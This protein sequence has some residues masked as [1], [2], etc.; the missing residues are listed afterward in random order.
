MPAEHTPPSFDSL[1][2]S[3]P[4]LQAVQ[5]VGYETPSPI[6][7]QC[8]PLLLAGDDLLGQAQTGTGKTAA[9]ALPLLSRIDTR[10]N[11]PQ[12][13][14]LA[15]TRELAIQVAEAFQTYAHHLKNFHVLP[16]Y[17][18][19]PYVQQLRALKRGAQV[20]VGTPGR[21]MDHIRRGTLVLDELSALVLDEADEMLRMGFIE[22][23]EWIL[24]QTPEN[25]QT[26][27]FSATM[28]PVI[29]KVANRHLRNAKEIHIKSSTSTAKTIHQRF[30]QVSAGRK[31]DALTRILEAE[32]IEAMLVFVRTKLLTVELADKLSARGFACQALNGDIAQNQREKTVNRLKKGEL[33]ILIA[34][35]VAARGLDVE[36]ISH[37]LN[38]DIPSDT[39][40]YVHRI[41]RTGRAGRKGE[42]ILFVTPKERRLLHSIEKATR[43]VIEPFRMPSTSDIN[44]QRIARFKQNITD[45]LEEQDLTLF[46][47]LMEEYQQ[48]Y[49]IE[50]IQVAAALAHLAQGS[51]PLLLTEEKSKPGKKDA[52]E[53][54][55]PGKR[56]AWEK[57]KPR[58]KSPANL[59]YTPIPLKDFPEIEMVRYRVDVGYAH[60]V[61][62]GNIVGAIANEAD[63]DSCYIGHIE[64]FDDFTTVDLPEG[65]P[66][67]TLHTLRKARVCGRKLEL[68][69]LRREPRANKFGRCQ[70]Q[71]KTSQENLA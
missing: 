16:V 13:L 49:E 60:D 25:R 33:D 61:K 37:V 50:P 26:A 69:E 32:D 1:G 17:G 45:T 38:Y 5:D 48:E 66:K 14:V 20:V 30:W 40:S 53:K 3:A 7:A 51:T 28:P 46:T 56:D 54:E 70:T 23:V 42:A 12:I 8:I 67:E 29:R 24:E 52:W 55:K 19:Q 43:Q 68:Q 11:K 65:M 21:I 9:F 47:R 10:A 36:R 39:E 35:D 22:D 59:E 64:I 34:T 4:I 6:Q 15:P 44:Q 58:S 57:D 27:L 31:L 63:I 41:G 18:G 71:A 2:L 62:P